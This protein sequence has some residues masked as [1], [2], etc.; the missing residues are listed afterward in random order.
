MAAPTGSLRSRTLPRQASRL[1]TLS[2]ILHGPW[3]RRSSSRYPFI[4]KKDLLPGLVPFTIIPW[5]ASNSCQQFSLGSFV[6]AIIPCQ[7][8]HSRMTTIDGVWGLGFRGSRMTPFDAS[9]AGLSPRGG[10]G[11]VRGLWI[12]INLSSAPR[13]QA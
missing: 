5:Q 11:L 13:H 8:W 9:T 7:C 6:P 3:A 4:R 12:L 10:G 2:L 1:R